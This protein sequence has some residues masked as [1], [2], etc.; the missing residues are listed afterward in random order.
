MQA[1]PLIYAIAILNNISIAYIKGIP[2]R[3]HFWFMSK[4]DAINLMTGSNL[5]DKRGV[6]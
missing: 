6:L 3:I 5:V 2:Y 1:L 4:D